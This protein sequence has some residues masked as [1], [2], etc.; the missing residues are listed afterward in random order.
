MKRGCTTS[1][2]S[3]ELLIARIFKAS[4]GTNVL[5]HFLVHFGIGKWYRHEESNPVTGIKKPLKTGA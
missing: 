1:V 4:L 5:V 2:I 3:Y